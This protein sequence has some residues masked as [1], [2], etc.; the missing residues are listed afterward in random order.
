[1]NL[2]SSFDS[3]PHLYTPTLTLLYIC[4]R[5]DKN[6][7]ARHVRKMPLRLL[8]HYCR[9]NVNKVLLESIGYLFIMS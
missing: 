6:L 8:C 5:Y 3:H 2:T 9:R 1:M 4:V 7:N